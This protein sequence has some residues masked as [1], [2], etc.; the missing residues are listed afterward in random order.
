M[1]P[2]R[3][4]GR[5]ASV[6]QAQCAAGVGPVGV[7]QKHNPG[8]HSKKPNTAWKKSPCQGASRRKDQ[9]GSRLQGEIY[10]G[11]MTLLTDSAAV[12]RFCLE[13]KSVGFVAVDTEFMRERTYWPILCLVQVAGPESAAVI[14]ALTPEIDLT[15]LLTLMAEPSILKV[16]HAARQDIEIFFNLSGAVPEPLFDTQIAAMVCG[17]G[18]AASYETLVS[19]LARTA[20]DKSS[21]FT[22]WA[23]RPL[24]ERQISYA[25]ADVIHLR[26]VYEGLQQRLASNG[27]AGWF[28]EE[29]AGLADPATYRNEPGEAWRR[30]RLRGR[31]DPR[32]FGVLR[33]LAAWRET[34]ARHRNLPRGRIMK[35][36]AVVEIAAHTPQ[37][38]EALGRT[39]SLGKGVAEGKLGNEILEAVQRGLVSSKA[40]EVPAPSKADAPPGL[41]PQIELLRVLLK[42]RCAEHQVAQRL[43]ASAED[44][45]AIAADDDAPVKALSGW[46]REIFGKDAL[47]LKHGRLAL[48]V[49]RNRISLVELTE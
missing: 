9:G 49:R 6:E 2:S 23:N 26:T 18:D 25:L 24:T 45:E 30:F 7:H 27:R 13:Q 33:G 46:R 15:P 42:Q 4:P 32:F 22:D 5:P 41:G 43:L 28:A 31:I 39:R 16:F 34:A 37:T 12:A 1:D 19:K 48:T 36:E 29:M 17:F 38:I 10:S 21:R 3:Q 11:A 8:R 14:D 20:L 40:L 44:L 47:A 35:D